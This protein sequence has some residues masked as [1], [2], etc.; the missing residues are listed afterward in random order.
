MVDLKPAGELRMLLFDGA[1]S[2][3]GQAPFSI[4]RTENAI[5]T[6]LD[7]KHYS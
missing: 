3:R 4:P 1:F 6:N 7:F 2:S 5:S